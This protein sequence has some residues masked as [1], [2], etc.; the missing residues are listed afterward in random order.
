MVL[1]CTTAGRGLRLTRRDLRSAAA[2]C[3]ATGCGVAFGQ[4]RV[5]GE[6]YEGSS[7]LELV[8]D[9]CG[10]VA[11]CAPATCEQPELAVADEPQLQE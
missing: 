6:V 2:T 1:C 10:A 5:S 11:A 9:V 4:R 7:P 3:L 8:D